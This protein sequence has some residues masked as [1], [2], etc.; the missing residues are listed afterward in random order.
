MLNFRIPGH[1][2]ASHQRSIERGIV[3][4]FIHI[5]RVQDYIKNGLDVTYLCYPDG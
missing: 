5:C 4:Y 3:F 2:F 1:F